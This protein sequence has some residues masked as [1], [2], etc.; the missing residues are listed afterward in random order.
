MF[1]GGYADLSDVSENINKEDI[2]N[3]NRIV[4]CM[5]GIEFFNYERP[6]FSDKEIKEIKQR[7]NEKLINFY[8][9]NLIFP[10]LRSNNQYDFDWK[11]TSINL[12]MVEIQKKDSTIMKQWNLNDMASFITQWR[13]SSMYGSTYYVAVKQKGD[14][15][16]LWNRN[17]SKEEIHKIKNIPTMII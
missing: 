12:N 8:K 13:F 7:Y 14:N 17:E 3:I 16:V 11:I 15:V 10:V 6:L 4:K 5:E 9:T 2:V 1:L